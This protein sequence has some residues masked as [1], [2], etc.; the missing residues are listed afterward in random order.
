MSR[1]NWKP[2]Y[3][4]PQILENFYANPFIAQNRSTCIT[5]NIVGNQIQIYNGIRWF[6]VIVIPEI[7]GHCLGQFAPTRKRPAPKLAKR[8]KIKGKN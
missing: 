4:H 2:I 1:S 3:I 5:I 6:A 7:V 8:Q